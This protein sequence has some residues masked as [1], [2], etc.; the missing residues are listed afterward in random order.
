MHVP[1]HANPNQLAGG[2]SK[3]CQCPP[4]GTVLLSYNTLDT[5]RVNVLLLELV[6]APVHFLRSPRLKQAVSTMRQQSSHTLRI[7]LCTCGRVRPKPEDGLVKTC[8]EAWGIGLGLGFKLELGIGPGLGLKLELGI[9]LGLGLK[10]ELG[11]GLGLG[12]KL[13]LGI[14]IGLA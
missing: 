13:E 14:G 9:G 12:F 4:A 1:R 3:P 6:C 8:K 10:P 5:H 11:I 2:S 7:I